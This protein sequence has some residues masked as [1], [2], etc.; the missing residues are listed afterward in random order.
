MCHAC[1][2]AA[3]GLCRAAQ[4]A[5]GGGWDRTKRSCASEAHAGNATVAAAAAEVSA[6][7]R[8]PGKGVQGTLQTSKL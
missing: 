3:L 5:G 2:I 1:G 4:L 6:G 7:V 8:K